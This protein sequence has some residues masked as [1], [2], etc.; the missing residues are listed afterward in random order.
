MV[1]DLVSL[2]ELDFVGTVSRRIV[3]LTQL[4]VN[5]SSS[6]PGKSSFSKV[7]G[8]DVTP[9]MLSIEGSASEIIAA[10]SDFSEGDLLFGASVKGDDVSVADFSNLNS[11]EYVSSMD[12][13]DTAAN[14]LA[15]GVISLISADIHSLEVTEA[16]GASST[17]LRTCRGR[18]GEF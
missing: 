12:V 10:G 11:L 17:N 7:D 1:L 6:C 2:V 8:L 5:G 16:S 15:E 9:D 13:E 18:A 3:L 14:I 4:V